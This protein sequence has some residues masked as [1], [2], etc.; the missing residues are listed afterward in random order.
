MLET[1]AALIIEYCGVGIIPY[2][3]DEQ[4]DAITLDILA[5]RFVGEPRETKRELVDKFLHHCMESTDMS[6]DYVVDENCPQRFDNVPDKG[7]THDIVESVWRE[8]FV[9]GIEHVFVWMLGESEY[10]YR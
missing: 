4:A 8:A 10:L 2:L 1:Q 6:A 9:E 5:H 3:T 7:K